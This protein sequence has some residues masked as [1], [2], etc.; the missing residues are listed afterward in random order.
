MSQ[1]Q[2]ATAGKSKGKPKRLTKAEKNLRKPIPELVL[3]T[4][5]DKDAGV[6]ARMAAVMRHLT[7]PASAGS[8]GAGASVAGAGAGAGSAS[9]GAGGGA[10]VGAPSHQVLTPPLRPSTRRRVAPDKWSMHT[11]MIP[12]ESDRYRVPGNVFSPL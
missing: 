6:K 4:Q 8:A 1:Y 2:K 11:G 5:Q 3:S 10:G 9:A 7:G 12:T